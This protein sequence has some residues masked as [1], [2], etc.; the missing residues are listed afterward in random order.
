MSANIWTHLNRQAGWTLDIPTSEFRT[1]MERVRCESAA[2][3]CQR[4]PCYG[5]VYYRT[6]CPFEP[7]AADL[8]F[9]RPGGKNGLLYAACAQGCSL[10]DILRWIHR[11]GVPIIDWYCRFGDGYDPSLGAW[12]HANWPDLFRF[13]KAGST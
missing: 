7:E 9:H 5:F 11:R 1:A 2:C 8:I 13:V 4:T 12:D 10:P 6:H 3:P